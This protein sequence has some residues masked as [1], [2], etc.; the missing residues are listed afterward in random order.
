M[1]DLFEC[2]YFYTDNANLTSIPIYFISPV[3]DSSLAL[4]N[5]SAVNSTTCNKK[6]FMLS[7]VIQALKQV[8]Y[9]PPQIVV[10]YTATG[11]LKSP[12]IAHQPDGI[13]LVQIHLIGIRDRHQITAVSV[14]KRL[15]LYEFTPWSRDL[16]SVVRIRESPY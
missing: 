6:F 11:L 15:G 1:Y 16:V 2:L 14:I 3:A 4:A 7:L 9:V 8:G 13:H 5:K 12:C 10:W